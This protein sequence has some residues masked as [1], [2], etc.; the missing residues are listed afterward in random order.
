MKQLVGLVLLLVGTI[1]FSQPSVE[2]YYDFNGGAKDQSGHGRH[3][4]F[5]DIDLTQ[6]IEWDKKGA[7]QFSSESE[8]EVPI[9]L[10][11][12]DYPTYT[13]SF[14]LKI[15]ESR[16]K[17]EQIGSFGGKKKSGS[18]ILKNSKIYLK[19][20]NRQV[21]GVK[22]DKDQWNNVAVCVD[23][24]KRSTYLFVN[25]KG[26]HYKT[27]YDRGYGFVKFGTC[28]SNSFSF[29]GELDELKIYS[30]LLSG[31]MLDSLYTGQPVYSPKEVVFCYLSEMDKNIVRDTP[32]SKGQILGSYSKGDTVSLVENKAEIN[33]WTPIM[34]EDKQAYVETAY[35]SKKEVSESSALFGLFQIP[36][37]ELFSWEF[38]Y[39]FLGVLAV[40]ILGIVCF[41][42]FDRLLIRWAARD[43]IEGS[44]W[45][46][47]GFITVGAVMA[48]PAL[49]NS[50]F[51]LSYL[52]ENFTIWP[53]GS[54]IC[55]WIAWGLCVMMAIMVIMAIVESIWRV[56][57]VFALLRLAYLLPLAGLAFIATLVVSMLVIVAVLVIVGGFLL[58]GLFLG[59]GRRFKDEWGN[60]YEEI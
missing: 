53:A 14:W 52:G 17:V 57:V 19:D 32:N 12:M 34:Y 60:V 5:S 1:S 30:G 28:Y 49:I 36:E 45:L 48:I 26:K 18:L 58:L 43:T 6:D 42:S 15:T 20:N 3:G 46:I 24:Q 50:D 59:G 9:D 11:E 56:G 38:L 23:N 21:G 27:T 55:V 31:T 54:G 2:V 39:V 40:I 41:Q 29:Y 4:E 10:N 22:I 25:G 47:Y 16:N 51:V 13:I 37:L 8:L 35:V 44:A 7:F 33:G